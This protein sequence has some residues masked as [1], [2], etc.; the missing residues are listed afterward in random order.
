MLPVVV[1]SD[2]TLFLL[3]L[4]QPQHTGPKAPWV[5]LRGRDAPILLSRA[6]G[7]GSL[8]ILKPGG[9]IKTFVTWRM[10]SLSAEG[11]LK[12]GLA[13]LETCSEEQAK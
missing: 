2:L 13:P 3:R 4:V 7:G 10:G 5:V 11:E 8:P 1:D 12:R 6:R 9:N